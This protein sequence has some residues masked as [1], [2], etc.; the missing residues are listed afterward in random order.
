MTDAFSI[1]TVADLDGVITQ[2]VRAPSVLNTQPWRFVV[3]GGAIL[4]FADRDRQL[5]A[6]DPDGRELTISCG[7][8]LYYL[9]VAA[10]HAGWDPAVVPFPIADEPDLLAA[11]TF[12]PVDPPTGDDRLFRA[13]TLRRTNRSPFTDEPVPPGVSTELAEAAAAEGAVLHVID[14]PAAKEAIARLVAAGV[15]AQGADDEVIDD[16]LA[17]LRPGRD[18]RPDGVR[19][20]V[21]GLWDRH[22]TVRTPP[23]AVA[24]YK[25]DLLREAPAVLVL[26]TDRDDP[27]AWLTAGQALGHA[28]VAAADHG[29]AASYANEPIEVGALRPKV[30]DL[31]GDGIP[32]M[33][34]RVGY[35]EV[36]PETARRYA[37]DVTEH[38]GG[39]A[40]KPLR[41]L[42]PG[43]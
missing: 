14:D 11:V 38:R 33:V 29:L 25:A 40:P 2:A 12:H 32:Q 37:R 34:F 17:W 5:P 42:H 20:S 10:R 7:A 41:G 23:S 3:E 13:L 39:E 16:I 24:A 1:P 6:L 21:Q 27:T 36:E 19:D 8:A 26:A 43:A 18:P 15:V 28:L 22:A 9:R 4:L 35:P 31:I 30:A